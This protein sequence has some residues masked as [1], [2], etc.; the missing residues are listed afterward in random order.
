MK[1]LFFLFISFLFSSAE[2]QK[3]DTFSVRR[4]MAG[5][6][7]K[8]AMD[9]FVQQTF[10]TNKTETFN[11]IVYRT[12][13]KITSPNTLIYF[14]ATQSILDSLGV[15]EDKN[16]SVGEYRKVPCVQKNDSVFFL[17]KYRLPSMRNRGSMVE[18]TKAYSGT[19]GTNTILMEINTVAN[20]GEVP[21]K[22][23]KEVFTL[24]KEDLL[25]TRRRR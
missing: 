9:T 17:I 5:Y 23:E 6:K 18:V 13:I 24:F 8:I 7:G 12:G 10:L 15:L 11:R 3:T 21:P 22:N 2:A 25:I 1:F 4:D 19:K 20:S 16:A 14:K